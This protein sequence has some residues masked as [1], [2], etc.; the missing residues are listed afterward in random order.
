MPDSSGLLPLTAAERAEL[1]K[2]RRENSKLKVERAILK[3]LSGHLAVAEECSAAAVTA[4]T[5]DQFRIKDWCWLA[6]PVNLLRV[7]QRYGRLYS[8]VDRE[9]EQVGSAVVAGGV[10]VV[11]AA[12]DLVEVEV[13]DQNSL[14]IVQW[15]GEHSA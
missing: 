10:K 6:L 3:K 9:A 12:N 14:L 13:S 4:V 11:A 1:T 5:R 8:P 2:L 15:P 7:V